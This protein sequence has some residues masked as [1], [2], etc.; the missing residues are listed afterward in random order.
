[1]SEILT[2]CSS[3]SAALVVET[4]SKVSFHVLIVSVYQLLEMSET[5]TY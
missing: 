1:M 4:G 5:V 3:D 2:Y